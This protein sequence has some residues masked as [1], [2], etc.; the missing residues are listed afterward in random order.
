[1]PLPN[2]IAFLKANR[3]L[4]LDSARSVAE[5]AASIKDNIGSVQINIRVGL[6]KAEL[7]V[8][9]RNAIQ[10]KWTGPTTSNGK[11][12][13]EAWRMQNYGPVLVWLGE[14]HLAT[15]R[16]EEYRQKALKALQD[17]ADKEHIRVEGPNFGTITAGSGNTVSTSTVEAN[18]STH[19]DITAPITATPQPRDW[20]SRR[21]ALVGGGFALLAALI[22]SPWWGQ[23]STTDDTGIEQ[24]ASP[25]TVKST[26][27]LDGKL[28]F[29]T[30][31]SRDEQRKQF[32]LRKLR[33]LENGLA[34]CQAPAGT[35]FFTSVGWIG[36]TLEFERGCISGNTT[37]DS[38][39]MADVEVHRQ[40]DGAFSFLLYS[41]SESI[42]RIVNGS[43]VTE[44]VL[45]ARPW[46][47][48]NQLVEVPL[49]SVVKG[50]DRTIRLDERHHIKVVDVQIDV[51]R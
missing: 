2:I 5:I 18:V 38:M 23:Q 33:P 22:S 11:V 40:A 21:V 39:F 36:H 19:A 46:D 10:R 47:A 25:H 1:M 27:P 24:T 50:S 30:V 15:I 20:S 43:G 32:N 3:A 49:A 7:E 37:A 8:D 14:I 6:G 51:H 9:D 29:A 42:H 16:E 45:S 31:A 35:Y 26:L 4:S 13:G 17:I 44:A 41:S 28:Q 34:S 48:I 12:E